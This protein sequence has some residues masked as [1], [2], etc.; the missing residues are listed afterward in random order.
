M[1]QDYDM[2]FAT[3]GS[4]SKPLNVV[5]EGRERVVTTVMEPWP[6][7][8]KR[9]ARWGLLGPSYRLLRK[10]QAEY[11]WMIYEAREPFTM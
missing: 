5:W 6:R 10:A 4:L 2:I 7:V 9:A 1:P 11:G 3:W 8:L